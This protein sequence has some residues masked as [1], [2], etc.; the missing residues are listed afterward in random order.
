MAYY[1]EIDRNKRRHNNRTIKEH[2]LVKVCEQID[3]ESV[4]LV[5][6]VAISALDRFMSVTRGRILQEDVPVKMKHIHYNRSKTNTALPCFSIS[7]LILVSISIYN[8]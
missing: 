5:Q 3:T 4:L 6:L 7:G 1:L 2:I 8:R